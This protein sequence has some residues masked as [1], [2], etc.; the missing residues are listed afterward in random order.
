MPYVLPLTATEATDV[1]QAGGK[2]AMLARLLQAGLPVPP[3]CVLTPQAL[4]AFLNTQPQAA[5]TAGVCQALRQACIPPD[6]HDT[7]HRG[8]TQ[9]GPATSGWAVR[10]SAVAEDSATASFAGVYDSFLPIQDEAIWPAI[11]SCWLSWYSDRALAYRQHLGHTARTPTM[12][13]VIQH[14]V[15]ARHAGVAF[16]VD[17]GRDD[18][19]RMVVHAAP[20]L[21]LA[22]VSGVVEPEQYSLRKGPDVQLMETRLLRPD[23][24]PLLSSDVVLALGD[25]LQ[26]IET[27]CQAPQD[28]EW[29]WD[30]TQLW[31]VQSRPIT[32]LGQS[33]SL[34]EP[35]VWTQANMK[36][37]MP[38]LVS[39]LSWS[40]I[41]P[42]LESAI[43]AQYGRWGYSWPQERRVLR[44]FWGRAYFNMSLFQQAAYEVFGVKPKDT[45][46]QLGGPGVQGFTPAGAPLWRQRWRWLWTTLAM[47]R[48]LNRVRKQAPY[49]FVQLQ[50]Y[51]RDAWQA[52]PHLDRK[53]LIQ[54]LETRAETDLPFLLVHLDLSAGMN[55]HFTLLRQ[56]IERY[57]PDAPGGMFAELVTG[58]G[59]VYSAE[60]SY[61]LWKLSR[62]A[63]QLPAVMTFLARR[64]WHVWQEALP[65]TDMAAPWQDFLDTYGHRG[66]YEVDMA[67][68][69]WREQPDY[70]FEVLAAYAALDAETAPFDPQAQRR[71]RQQAERA[72]LQRLPFWCRPWFRR[73]LR[74]SQAFSRLREQS[75]S[76]L[77]RLIDL[78][79]QH[80][81]QAGDLLVRDGLIEERNAVFFLKLDELC[82][83]LRGEADGQLLRQH[84]AH[85]RLER[86]RHAMRQPPDAF[87]GE[88]PL[89]S[90]SPIPHGTRLDGLPSSP[91]RVI[92]TARVLRTPQEGTRLQAGEILV[93]PST[94]PGWTPLFLLASGLIMET[95]GYLSHGAIVA[96]E[97]GIPAVLNVSLATQRIPDGATVILD[98][99]A[100]SVQIVDEGG[101]LA[102]R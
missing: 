44:R 100:G 95:G 101:S 21:G 18:T 82:Q 76:H 33:L 75:K 6:L 93:A 48:L 35:D 87:I 27:L 11:R 81:L 29:A 85:R 19:T 56:L 37:V 65:Q 30:G 69:R 63:R 98:G 84:L 92:A 14:M 43:R 88:R 57:I 32:T 12:A 67:N 50:Q 70:L 24:P 55:G 79:R 3:G 80:A 62:L 53:A 4:T 22:V 91:G 26:R 71:R 16:T 99:G 73:T 15:P 38:G 61:A 41:R 5:T 64:D 86:Q 7:L 28:V 46:E 47:V 45:L 40:I 59:Q 77:V 9:L 58:L 78:G 66:L 39:P 51:C 90:A 25:L 94:D 31:I 52:L 1:T 72:A 36:D 54:V 96:R 8:L 49:H 20:G 34:H 83:A 97:Y 60:H 23:H 74:Q 10:S 17:P 68:P 102:A 2:G 42:Q 89:Y 13:V